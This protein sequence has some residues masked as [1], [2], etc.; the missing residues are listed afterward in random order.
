MFPEEQFVEIT[1][2]RKIFVFWMVLEPCARIFRPIGELYSLG[3]SELISL[4]PD[5]HFEEKYVFLVKLV[6]FMFFGFWTNLF[7]CFGKRFWHSCQDC[8]L[9]IHLSNHF[10]TKTFFCL[11]K[12]YIFS[13]LFRNLN[14]KDETSGRNFSAVAELHSPCPQEHSRAIFF[15]KLLYFFIFFWK[16]WIFLLFSAEIFDRLVE[17]V[18]FALKLKFFMRKT[19][20]KQIS[21]FDVF[22]TLSG[23]FAAFWNNFFPMVCSQN[24]ILRVQRKKFKR[25]TLLKTS[26]V[27]LSFGVLSKKNIGFL[28]KIF[29]LSC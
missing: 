21:F 13:S 10:E 5:Q 20:I 2:P 25:K 4:C 22:Q 29:Q 9:R 23:F 6:F 28:A 24:C 12:Q 8:I 16:F 7:L 17:G 27:S 1:F 19:F 15:E 14:E 26:K 18:F 3:L 11:S